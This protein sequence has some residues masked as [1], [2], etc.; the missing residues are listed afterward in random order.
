MYVYNYSKETKNLQR[1]QHESIEISSLY[2]TN[3]Q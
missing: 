2:L 1:K 3:R